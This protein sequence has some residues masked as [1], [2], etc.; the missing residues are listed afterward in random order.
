YGFTTS[1]E[2]TPLSL[3]SVPSSH[4]A[5]TPLST[6]SPLKPTVSKGSFCSDGKWI[7]GLAKE[8]VGW[9]M[10]LCLIIIVVLVN[11]L[12]VILGCVGLYCRWGGSC[13]LVLCSIAYFWDS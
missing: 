3:M 6:G 1:Y 9:K 10:D 13:V 8:D 2:P 5:D 12:C 11:K 4:R 7:L